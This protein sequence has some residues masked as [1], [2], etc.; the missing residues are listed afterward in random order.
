MGREANS[1]QSW[2][3]GIVAI[4]E[5]ALPRWTSMATFWIKNWVAL[6]SPDC[7][8]T[9]EPIRLTNE[10][11]HDPQAPKVST[12]K[13]EKWNDGI[14]EEYFLHLADSAEF[15]SRLAPLAEVD[16]LDGAR[17]SEQVKSQS[18]GQ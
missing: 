7:S 1:T 15:T 8:I 11:A 10:R 12:H 13:G 17:V 4:T 6:L 9:R 2:D 16:K 5:A 14:R 18:K 3:D